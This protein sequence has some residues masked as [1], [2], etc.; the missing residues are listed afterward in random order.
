MKKRH[1]I[2][3][4]I[5]II[6][7]LVLFCIKDAKKTKTLICTVSG[8]FYE[9]K[10]TTNLEIKVNSNKV[11]SI[12]ET[13]NVT[14]PSDINKQALISQIEA[15]GKMEVSNTKEGIK[16]KSNMNNS[17]FDTLG[18][19]R[20]ITYSELKSALELQGYTCE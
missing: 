7:A 9:M 18:L 1:V 4:T 10:S 16:L 8:E 13:I 2:M 20:N 3:I 15:S 5:V 17:Y 19:D 11:R 12:T 14:V 6:F